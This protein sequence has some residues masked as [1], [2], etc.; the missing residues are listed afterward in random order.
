MITLYLCI[1]HCVSAIVYLTLCI[2]H[3]VFDMQCHTQLQWLLV[4]AAV[5]L[6]L[7]LLLKDSRTVPQCAICVFVI[8][9]LS[10]CIC[11]A[12]M[13]C[14]AVSPNC[15]AKRENLASAEVQLLFLKDTKFRHVL[16]R[17]AMYLCMGVLE[18]DCVFVQCVFVFL[19]I[20]VF[21]YVCICPRNRGEI[22]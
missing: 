2:C 18:T 13:P 3:C 4:T 22:C 11:H 6:L 21:A 12:D 8:V 5:E 1:C 17:P 19:C 9:Y 20:C 10:L 14:S 16:T 15:M 7:Q